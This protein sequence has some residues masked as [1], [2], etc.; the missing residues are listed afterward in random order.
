MTQLFISHSSRNNAEAVALSEWLISEG[1]DDLFLDIDPE[2]GMVAG[3]RWERALHRAASRCDAVLFLI[4]PDWLAS[5][6]CRREFTIAQQLGKRLFVLLIGGTERS[7]IPGHIKQSWQIVNLFEGDDHGAAREVVLPNETAP[8]FVYFSNSGLARLKAGLKKAG[9]DPETF[10]WPP[11]ND[12]NRSPY[13]GM[14][15]FEA[16]D[17]GI[18]FGREAPTVEL[19]AQLRG[20][21]DSA[22]PRFLAI[23]GASGA[24]K[25]SFLRAGV[26]PRLARDDRHYLPLPIIRPERA[27]ITGSNGL[28]ASLSKTGRQYKLNWDRNKLEESIKSGAQ[29]LLPLLG[30]LATLHC[31]RVRLDD[32]IDPPTLIIAIDQC[33]EVFFAESGDESAQLLRILA[34]LLAS[35]SL[36]LIVLCTIRSDHYDYLQNAPELAGT[37]QRTFSLPPMPRGALRQVI[38]GPLQRRRDESRQLRVDALLTDALLKDIDEGVGKDALPLL[39][40]AM[41]RMYLEF[42]DGDEL[43]LDDYNRLGRI[44]GA[45]ESAVNIALADVMRVLGGSLGREGSLTLLRHALIPWMVGIDRNNNQP[46][47]K[48]AYLSQIPEASRKVLEHFVAHRLLVTDVAGNGEVTI[49]PVHE[50]LLRKWP[51]LRGWLEEDGVALSVL[52]SVKA[53]AAEWR[54]RAKN[55][56]WLVHTGGRLEYAEKLLEREDISE[57]LDPVDR[58]YLFQC[59]ILHEQQIAERQTHLAALARQEEFVERSKARLIELTRNSARRELGISRQLR[60]K[61][62]HTDAM[63]HLA[64]ALDSDFETSWIDA[65]LTQSLWLPSYRGAW[66]VSESVTMLAAPDSQAFVVAHGESK[67]FVYHYADCRISERGSGSSCRLTSLALSHKGNELVLSKNNGSLLKVA[68]P[69]WSET[70]LRLE[71]QAK[72]DMAIYSAD[73]SMIA[74]ADADGTV[75]VIGKSDGLRSAVLKHPESVISMQFGLNDRVLYTQTKNGVVYLWRLASVTQNSVVIASY[76]KSFLVGGSGD[77]LVLVVPRLSGPIEVRSLT[78]VWEGN[79][80]GIEGRAHSIA[81]SPT[82]NEFY[83]GT[84]SGRVYRVNYE[85]CRPLFGLQGVACCLDVSPDGLHLVSAGSEGTL[86]LWSISEE[87]TIANVLVPDPLLRVVFSPDGLL[88][89]SADRKGIVQIRTVR[90]GSVWCAPFEASDTVESFSFSSDGRSLF[91]LEKTGVVRVWGVCG[92]E[93]AAMEVRHAGTSEARFYADGRFFTISKS[94]QEA[95]VWDCRTGALLKAFSY[96]DCQLG[97]SLYIGDIAESTDGDLAAVV[98]QNGVHVFS[99]GRCEPVGRAIRGEFTSVRLSP[100]GSH[101]VLFDKQGF[102][103]VFDVGMGLDLSARYGIERSIAID[104]SS[105]GRRFVS[106]SVEGDVALVELDSQGSV[107]AT[108][109]GPRPARDVRFCAHDQRF[110]V[111]FDDGV[112]AFDLLGKVV[113]P[114]IDADAGFLVAHSGNFV[115]VCSNALGL[116]VWHLISGERHGLDIKPDHLI[117]HFS[118]G[119]SG[120]IIATSSSAGVQLWN[121]RTGEFGYSLCDEGQFV[122]FSPDGKQLLVGDTTGA[123]VYEIPGRSFASAD[124]LKQLASRQISADGKSVLLEAKACHERLASLTLGPAVLDPELRRLGEWLTSPL[125]TRTVAP[126][127]GQKVADYI[128]SQI[129]PWLTS[130]DF[131]LSTGSSQKR[132]GLRAELERLYAVDPGHPLV[133]LALA[134]LMPHK[135]AR[136]HLRR[137]GCRSSPDGAKSTLSVAEALLGGR[138]FE[139]AREMASMVLNLGTATEDEMKRARLILMRSTGVGRIFELFKRYLA[140]ARSQVLG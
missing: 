48:V 24:G 74:L 70:Q 32:L 136:S 30:E 45:I 129:V 61:R 124:V 15:H 3:E 6:W 104:F 43:D 89:A 122:S 87:S 78:S 134:G 71:Q 51:Q 38:E 135:V 54:A 82:G 55:T 125:A 76:A 22:P 20:L 35:E 105:D 66:R 80:F 16:E 96:S 93:C 85:E 111:R 119:S 138:V 39:A 62:E 79:H 46:Y 120:D 107:F 114:F 116:R 40:F 140:W 75:F 99:I 5:E 103:C 44:E 17:A 98:A 84:T 13:R 67:V 53:S 100:A 108:N 4:G 59:R 90:D 2:R 60:A 65:S 9:L 115:A 57:G 8:R 101:I 49:E 77:H 113:G 47:R 81:R 88:V 92:N 23:L 41:E 97:S 36:N 137:L 102:A 132:E 91:V 83:V 37:S 52:D 10:P 95:R 68:L 29:G 127:S 26:L 128:D 7:Q 19:L 133:L 11:A 21:R 25:S 117:Q 69:D 130:R 50:A 112:Q 94:L 33:E 28:F 31:E 126:L 123:K 106:I 58:E 18:F 118:I 110:V 56:V 139:D 131:G 63:A 121:V 86:V 73:D 72:V 42:R 14:S 34:G 109:I 1:W 12:P 27:A 64:E